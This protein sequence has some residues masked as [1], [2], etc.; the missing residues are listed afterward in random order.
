MEKEK[1]KRQQDVRALLE[2]VLPA[3]AERGRCQRYIEELD[4]ERKQVSDFYA[5]FCG[6]EAATRRKE[7]LLAELEAGESVLYERISEQW[8]QIQ[9]AE[10]VIASLPDARERAILQLR[11][12][13]GL[14]WTRVTEELTKFGFWYEERQVYRLHKSALK[15]AKKLLPS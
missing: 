11:Y 6:G 8:R 2:G 14:T 1:G 9:A 15:S 3:R 12:V 4:A 10:E 7:A 5:L 13:E